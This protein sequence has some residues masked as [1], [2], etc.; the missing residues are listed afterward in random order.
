MDLIATWNA[1]Y[2]D[3]Q[4]ERWKTEPEKLSQDWRF[5]FE[6]FELALS[7]EATA[8]ETVD[9]G[10]LERRARPGCRLSF[11]DTGISAT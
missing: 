9:E 6:G 3:A 7:E 4:Y 1:D 5:F 2:I 8:G 10:R 11:I